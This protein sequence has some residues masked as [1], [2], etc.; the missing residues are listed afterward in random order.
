MGS[1]AREKK[2]RGGV[3]DLKTEKTEYQVDQ[4]NNMISEN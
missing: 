4:M 3:S 2:A 1:R